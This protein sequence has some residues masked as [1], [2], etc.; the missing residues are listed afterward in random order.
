[1]EG[2]VSVKGLVKKYGALTAVND[3]GF[4]VQKGDLF[5][6]LGP[7]GAGKST[8]INIICTLLDKTAGEVL[9]DGCK[10][11]LKDDEVRKR[12]GV[13]F[14]DNIL[15][16]LLTV[17]ENLTLR[18]SLYGVN[19]RELSKRLMRA[20]EI[21]GIEDLLNRRYGKLS[22]GQKRRSEIA[23]ALLHQPKVLFLD[24]PTTG[25]DPQ[26][27]IRV[28]KTIRYLQR[29]Y[30]MTVF[31][32]THYMEEAEGAD[33]VAII[34]SGRIVARGTPNELKAAYSSDV[35][36]IAPKDAL[37][38]AS[39]FKDKG[40]EAK[41]RADMLLVPVGDSMEALALLKQIEDNVRAFEVVRGNMDDVFIKITGHAIREDE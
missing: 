1:L 3:I 39:W 35:L 20:A 9:V 33:D 30:D 6:F 8:T 7:N 17:K 27:R 11:G 18:G 29:E 25:L 16:D 10:V 36:K 41:E 2:I 5:A 28:W 15:D 38:A 37:K 40:Y 12:I 4:E 21:V 14:Q 26:T 31:L 24:E 22:G 32:T 23:R 13:V 19:G 34:D